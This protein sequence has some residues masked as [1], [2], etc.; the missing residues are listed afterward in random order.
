[1][2]TAVRLCIHRCESPPFS[3]RD[4]MLTMNSTDIEQETNG[5]YSFNREEKL[6][7]AKVKALMEEA[8]Q[9]YYAQL[10]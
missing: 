8:A 6:D 3:L 4:V 1:M 9:L 5:L 2:V 10:K 7:S